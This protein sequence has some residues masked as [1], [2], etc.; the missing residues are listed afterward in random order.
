[1][2][3]H[4]KYSSISFAQ[5]SGKIAN[6]NSNTSTVVFSDGTTARVFD[7]Q[8]LGWVHAKA[9]AV[10]IVLAPIMFVSY[11]E[12][13]YRFF[14]DAFYSESIVEVLVRS[15]AAGEIVHANGTSVARR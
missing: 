3:T 5:S 11:F 13:R 14:P 10:L 6:Y 2:D 15:M 12:I 1:M 8:P 4:N 7:Q 9:L